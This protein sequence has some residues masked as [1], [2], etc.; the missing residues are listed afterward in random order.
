[1]TPDGQGVVSASRDNT[2]KVWDLETKEV[3]ATF[4]CDSAAFCCAFSEPL[5]LILA[6]DAGGH[7]HFLRLEAPKPKD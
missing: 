6:G 3:L 7:L 1:M 5:K 4:S 2:L